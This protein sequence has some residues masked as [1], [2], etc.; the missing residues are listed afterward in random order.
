[1]KESVS[2]FWNSVGFADTFH[3]NIYCF[4]ARAGKSLSIILHNLLN[5]YL[6]AKSSSDQT[7]QTLD[8]GTPTHVF[9]DPLKPG[10]HGKIFQNCQLIFK[11]KDPTYD[12]K[13]KNGDNTGFVKLCVVYSNIAN[14]THHTQTDF[15]KKKNVR[16]EFSQNFSGSNMISK[17][18]NRAIKEESIE[19]ICERIYNEEKYYNK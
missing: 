1:M 18:I 17:H 7:D 15:I 12:N 13:A 8:T 19:M 2:L 16:W 3:G 5:E 11:N 10:S 6:N 9:I 4:Y 14:T